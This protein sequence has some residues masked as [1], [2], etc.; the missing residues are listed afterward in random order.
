[1]SVCAP[2]IEHPLGPATAS[3]LKLIIPEEGWLCHRQQGKRAQIDL[4]SAGIG[5]SRG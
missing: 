5:L 3:G 4:H 1:M 2:K